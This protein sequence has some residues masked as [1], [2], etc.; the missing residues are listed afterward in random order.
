LKK[1]DWE[2]W[3]SKLEFN[4][5]LPKDFRNG[6][7]KQGNIGTARIRWTVLMELYSAGSLPLHTG[8]P[9]DL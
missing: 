2:Y 6:I 5:K 7:L 1:E 9:K 3:M 4:F 8:I